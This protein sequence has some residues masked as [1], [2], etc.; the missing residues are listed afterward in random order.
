MS[1]AP[2]WY[3][4]GAENVTPPFA[5][6]ARRTLR[7]RLR[8]WLR[9]RLPEPAVR[10]RTMVLYCRQGL[11]RQTTWPGMFSEVFSVLGALDYGRERGAAALRV[12]FRSPHYLDPERGPNW[13]RYFFERDVMPLG[14]PAGATEVHLD[15]RIA[16]YGRYGG[17]G[18]RIYGETSHL[19]PMTAGV[20]RGELHRLWSS[21]I[22]PRP[23]V[24]DKVDA[25]AAR[26]FERDTRVVGVHYRGTDTARHYPFYRVPYDAY[27][28]EIRRVLEAIGPSRYRVFVATDE[29]EFVDFMDKAFPGQAICS[30]ESPRVSR[31][32][33]AIHFNRSI[34]ATGYQKGE[35]ALVDCLLLAR[36]D[37]LVKGRSNLSD[38]S[39]IV[40]PRVPYSFWIGQ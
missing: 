14:G 7:S 25:F 13:W 12:D 28:D 31:D 21:H 26:W 3:R 18:D 17:F 32:E 22:R 38:A 40:N 9:N 4:T 24:I 36:A 27:A 8:G 33:E 23:E 6:L 35:A 11:R 2:A 10:E 30:P 15:Q 39:L 1:G 5:H 20:A 34:A 16:K 29:T 37:W 19:Y